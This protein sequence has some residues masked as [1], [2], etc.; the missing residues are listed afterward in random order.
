MDGNRTQVHDAQYVLET[1]MFCGGE[2]PPGGL[3]L[4]D[5]P[6][7]LHPGVIDE[8]LFGGFGSGQSTA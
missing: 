5:L 8:F 7:S 6:E 4:V 2:D 1:H 3:Q